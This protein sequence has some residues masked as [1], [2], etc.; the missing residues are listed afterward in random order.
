MSGFAPR[1]LP[2]DGLWIASDKEGLGL[3]F[4]GVRL[5]S[6]LT[7]NIK[8]KVRLM[9]RDMPLKISAAPILPGFKPHPGDRP[10]L[11]RTHRLR[12]RLGGRF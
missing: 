7:F 2:Y 3:A 8:L 6:S 5:V 10:G 4:S 1:F 11:R 12:Q 9:S